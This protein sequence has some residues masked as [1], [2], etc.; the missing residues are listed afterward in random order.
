MSFALGELG[1]RLEEFYDMPWCEYL[2][3]CYAW[4]RMER[5]RWRHTRLI[6]YESRI[7]SHL[8]PKSLPTNI[9]SYMPLERGKKKNKKSQAVLDGLE[10]LKKERDEFYR[11]NRS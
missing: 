7:G 9:E 6:A 4:E 1:L 2:I 3:K 10:Q 11:N 5:E 8:N